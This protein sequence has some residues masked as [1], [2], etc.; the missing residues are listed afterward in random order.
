M[1]PHALA[2]LALL[3]MSC[4]NLNT[5][6]K[7]ECNSSSDCTGDLV[8]R[9]GF[10]ESPSIAQDA[11]QGADAAP[12]VDATNL[13]EDSGGSSQDGSGMSTDGS[14]GDGSTPADGSTS[15]D[16]SH[17]ADASPGQDASPAMDASPSQ[18]ASPGQ[19]ASPA[20]DASP[21]PDASPGQDASSSMDASVTGGIV[22]DPCTLST[23]C[24]GIT[25]MIPECLTTQ[26]PGWPGGYCSESCLP[27]MDM[28]PTG[29][30]CSSMNFCVK[31]CHNPMD[32]RT[33]YV[34]LTTSSTPPFEGCVPGG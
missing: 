30:I 26:P 11:G 31:A 7:K 24:T 13:T 6:G 10:C 8:C 5:Q 1:K 33:G 23:D 27:S 28:C 14:A 12:G 15:M 2:T 3:S 21:S 34:C 4:S 9:S 25:N 16:G 17:P 32:C 18:D 22:G 20:M 19:D 29:S